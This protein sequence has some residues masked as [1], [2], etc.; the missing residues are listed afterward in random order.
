M[1]NIRT[2][3]PACGQD[4]VFTTN[5]V[6][7]VVTNED[8]GGTYEFECPFCHQQVVKTATPSEMQVLGWAMEEPDDLGPIGAV[9]QQAFAEW[10][11]SASPGEIFELLRSSGPSAG[12]GQNPADTD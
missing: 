3:C 7:L 9:L 10:L 12:S 8:G 4:V 5:D 2:G 6:S 1:K 11:K